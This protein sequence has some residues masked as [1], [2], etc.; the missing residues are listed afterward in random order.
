MK[1]KRS[2]TL[3]FSKNRRGFFCCVGS[4]FWNDHQSSKISLSFFFKLNS[5]ARPSPASTPNGCLALDPYSR[6]QADSLV[7]L[8]HV[9]FLSRTDR[10]TSPTVYQGCP[11]HATSLSQTSRCLHSLNRRLAS[12]KQGFLCC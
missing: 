4:S 7:S 2:F 5:Q 11:T 10:P 9:P 6:Q 3:L 8:A 1:H 12:G